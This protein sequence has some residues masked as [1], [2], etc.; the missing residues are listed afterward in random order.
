MSRSIQPQ[1]RAGLNIQPFSHVG[2]P[3]RR[4]AK[5][6]ARRR[7]FLLHLDM[8]EARTLLTGLTAQLIKD[9]NAVDTYPS[10]LT[11]AGSNL[12]SLV[13]DSTNTGQ[14]LEVTSAGGTT[15]AVMDFSPTSSSG[16][17]A[18]TQLT[19]VGNDVYFRANPGTNSTVSTDNELWV[20]D[21][22]AL[23]T[24]P[25]SIP[26]PNITEYDSL[27]ALGSNL[28][29][30]VNADQTGNDYQM[31]AVPPGS[32]TP[33]MLAD[34]GSSGADFVGTAGSTE[35]FSVGG[36]LWS[37]D[38]TAPNT[39][40][41]MGSGNNAIPTPASVF[42]FNNATY[43]FSDSEGQTTIETIG[44]SGLTPIATVA[45][46]ATS[47]VVVGS[48]FYF[49]AGGSTD[50]D[51]SQLWVSDGTLAGTRLVDDFS[52]I[53]S[54]STPSNLTNG[55]GTLFFTIAGADG[56]NE[57][58][59]SSGTIQ[60]TALVKDLGVSPSFSSYSSGY[61]YYGSSYSQSGALSP[62]G[63]TLFF[64]ADDGTHGAELWADTVATGTTQLVDDIDPGSAGSAPHDFVDFNNSLYFAAYDGS[65]PQTNQLWT[66]NGP[67]QAT[68]LV[69]SFSPAVTAGASQFYGFYSTDF[70]TLGAKIFLP[71]NDGVH[72]TALWVTDGTA[73]GTTVLARLDPFSFASMGGTEYF[74]ADGTFSSSTLGLWKTDGTVQGTSEVK[75]LSGLTGSYSYGANELVA[76]N[77]KLY[78]TTS[79]GS[80]GSDLWVSDG[81]SGGTLLVKDFALAT[82]VSHY[83][84]G[85]VSDLTAFGGKVVFIGDDGT[86][87]SQVWVSDG[88]LA[89]TQMLTTVNDVATGSSSDAGG[90]EPESLVVAGSKLY[91]F[92]DVPSTSTS[93]ENPQGLWVSDGTPGGT[94]EFFTIPMLTPP[95]QSYAA[96]ADVANLTA[97][98]SDLFF[99]A[100]Y[101]YY[102]GGE[103][104]HAAELW[105]SDGTAANTAQVAAPATGSPFR[106][107]ADFNAVG[108]LLLFQAGGSSG[109][110]ELWASNGTSMGTALVKVLSSASTYDYYQDNG[111][112]SLVANGVLYFSSNDGVDGD[113]LWQSDGTAAGTYLIDDINPGSASSNPTPLAVVSGQL[114]MLANDGAHGAELMKLVSTTQP[115]SPEMLA[116]PTQEITLG[117]T[118]TFDVSPYVFDSDI[119]ALPLTYALEPSAPAGGVPSIDPN[120]G[121][122]TWSTPDDQATGP[123]TFTVIVSDSDN[124]ALTAMQ[125]LTIDVDDLS[126]PSFSSIPEQ[127]VAVGNTLT[128]D[129][130]QYASD[131]NF[132]PLPLTFTLG[133]AP[134]GATID[135]TTGVVT[136][137]TTAMQPTGSVSFT[138]IATDTSDPAMTDSQTF[139]VY[140]DSDEPPYLETIPTQYVNLG[141]TL[142]LNLSNYVYDF[143]NPPLTYSLATGAPSGASI[144]PTTGVVTFTPV[145]GQALGS[146]TLGFVATDA[147][148][149]ALTTTGSITVDVGATGTLRGPVLTSPPTFAP[150]VLVGQTL[151]L[152]I[153]QYASDPNIP[154]LALTYSLGSGA[155]AGAT[156]NATTGLITWATAAN[157]ALAAYSFPVIVSDTNTPPLTAS[158]TYIVDV[159]PGNSITT[160]FLSQ[161]PTEEANVGSTFQFD[162]SHY[163]SNLNTPPIP[164]T[165]GLGSG[166]PSGVAINPQTGLI[167]WSI[168]ADVPLNLVTIPVTISDYLTPSDTN[169]QNLTVQLFAAGDILTPIVGNIPSQSAAV[170]QQIELNVSQYISNPSQ[171]TLAYSLTEP[172]AGASI[173]PVSGVFTWTP[174]AAE[175]G[176]DFVSVTVSNDQTASVSPSLLVNVS[177]YSA[178]VL[179]HIP[180]QTLALNQ[181]FS[182]DLSQ[183]VTDP[184]TG[185][186]PLTYSLNT[187]FG[188]P[189]GPTINS[190]TGL[191][192]WTPTSTGSSSY[193]V[194][195]T[196]SQSPSLTASTTFT[197]TVSALAPVVQPIPAQAVTIG[198]QLQ[199]SVT[200]YASDPNSPPLFLSYSLAPGAPAGASV[201]YFG[202]FSWTPASTQATGPVSITLVVTDSQSPPLSVSEAFTV[203]VAPAPIVAPAISFIPVEI[204]TVGKTFNFDV[205]N[206]ASDPNTPALTL[207]YALGAGAPQGASINSQTGIVAWTPSQNQTP[208]SYP[209]TVDVTDSASPSQTTVAGFTVVLST[210]SVLPPALTAIPT[211]SATI[212]QLFTLN[213]SQ[214]ASDPNTPALT[215]SYA[216]SGVVPSGAN[217]DMNS[218][219]LTW[220]PASGQATGDTSFTVVVSD[221]STPALT[222]SRTFQVDVV[223][224]P[225]LAPVLSTIPS[226]TVIVGQAFSFNVS[227]FA[228]D[229]NTPA[230][231][232]K[233]ALGSGAPSGASINLTTGLISWTPTSNQAAG[234]ARFTIIVSDT[235]SPPLTASGTLTVNVFAPPV[236]QT[237]PT[238]PAT[239]ATT[240][241]LDLSKYASDPNTPSSTLSYQLNG[242]VP[243]GASIDSTSGILTWIV[244]ANQTVGNT[245]F[246][247]T[248]SETSGPALTA[249][250]PF[251]VAVFATAVQPPALSAIPGQSATIGQP[252]HFDV[253]TYASDPNTPPLTLTFAL[254]SGAPS[255]ANINPATGVITWTPAANQPTGPA[256]FTIIV[257]DGSSPPLTA[258]RA[259]TV[260]VAPQ[261]QPTQSAPVI[262]TVPTQNVNVG[263]GLQLSVS[264]FASDPNSPPLPL[265][266]S[267][268][269]GAPSGVSINSTS[270]VLTWS[271][272]TNQ[273][274]G[275]YPIT[276]QVADNGS[277]QKTA[278]T[279]FNINVVDPSPVTISTASVSTKKGFSITLTFSGP[280]N[281]STASNVSNYI[282]TLP[283]KKPKSKKKPVPPP[284][285][286]KLTATYNAATNQVVLKGPKT[287]KTSPALTLTVFGTGSAGIA[288]LDG[289]LL[290]GSGGQPGTNYVASVTAKAVKAVAAVVVKTNAR[291]A[292][293]AAKT[294]GGAGGQGTINRLKTFFQVRTGHVK[295][296]AHP[297]RFA[298]YLTGRTVLKG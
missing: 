60:G 105:T 44:A 51:A 266:Y 71:L 120:T 97:V 161:P 138:V 196:D 109:D 231:A 74:L 167:T 125:T 213:L 254:A 218:G 54:S 146:L 298:S 139:S 55:A 63:G 246:S 204:A 144:N 212:G 10:S 217:I 258:S 192:T 168:P 22:T 224:T 208:G 252:F 6:K 8:L 292:Q 116:L 287:V 153:S 126:A 94:V 295:A 251:T 233:Y 50:G 102:T 245:A 271:V 276:V 241:N 174:T 188:L 43:E 76:S 15:T 29:V 45:S 127:T 169:S 226:Q 170:G 90:A 82:G 234:S 255:G 5:T 223:S 18:P 112:A 296:L 28:L 260:T 20:S 3:G 205:S 59:K 41:L 52:S 293:T 261:I 7:N 104:L 184:N 61:S 235:S 166:A 274:V 129:V 72:G 30:L 209:F 195:V 160:P 219:I 151:S 240:F 243:P 186:Y 259:L 180:A 98:G 203:N 239:V 31:W 111:S 236:I 173:D 182:L 278:S 272:G 32:A 114:V 46:T 288:K 297:A 11:P 19:A 286:V 67:G 181:P 183:Y 256:N 214:Y 123:V 232:L 145:S 48:Q 130:S 27:T 12:F 69:A 16:A 38:G 264:N 65:S 220:T 57:L 165:Y 119:A 2:K 193:T 179:A 163:V 283:A 36:D 56:L 99:S 88:T 133:T 210:S 247:L 262:G 75:D 62:V 79:D 229:P 200:P 284:V 124:P 81:T 249:T 289:L 21:G 177:Q 191:L 280:V 42:A 197:M 83:G 150:R 279:S 58:W 158:Q 106:S 228:S 122:F 100:S 189:S 80:E 93:D 9:V 70:G 154:A 172:L 221:T 66:S 225:V 270:G 85:S 35:Y 13:A 198:N 108:G 175:L 268:A 237:I 207:S 92:A 222:A 269:A 277:P 164:F 1:M 291:S 68:T 290:A 206:Y 190:A 178:P 34:F 155:P 134:T 142:T 103:D 121:I 148:T 244:P 257:S 253:S 187:P 78:F 282:L 25:V 4:S 132:P 285:R 64:T 87:G 185:A 26:N 37:T 91:F 216:L 113:E 117:Q 118:V 227:P 250:A 39:Q 40:E 84:Y 215:L 248:V 199:F 47:P 95:G 201:S 14:E 273:Q 53:S 141:Q 73:G 162:M 140:V 89:G 143:S 202:Q 24:V 110:T 101:Y 267:L 17:S 107:L 131:P 242:V 77:G 171:L 33:T 159:V 149:P 49:A 115:V 147:G 238:K 275:L 265:T 23:G 230:L 135:P 281:A 96:S 137:A 128:F 156:I 152:S 194:T 294:D 263:Q 86:H 176:F 136:W 211:T 157:Q